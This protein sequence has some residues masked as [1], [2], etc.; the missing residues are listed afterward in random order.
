M[1]CHNCGIDCKR[2][3]FSKQ[4]WQRHRCNQCKRTFSDVP[5]KPLDNLRV[6]LAKAVQVVHLLVEGVGIRA[7]SRLSGLH[8]QTVLNILEIAGDK[9]ARLLDQK[10]RNVQVESVQADELWSYV[11]CKQNK[12]INKDPDIGDQYTFLAIDQQSKLIISHLMGKR[13]Y[14]TAFDFV[15]DLKGR[16]DGRFQLTTDQFQ[17][18]VRAVLEIFGH[19]IDFGQQQKVFG[20]AHD[21][22]S[23]MTARRYSPPKIVEVNTM[24]HNRASRRKPHKHKPR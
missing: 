24:I 21:G 11:Y 1:T 6:P 7:A 4:G 15:R 2:F 22:S 10:V 23:N 12:N 3:G 20:P 5:E 9:C 13:D 14:G 17:G 18:Y 8:Q 19:E 16:V